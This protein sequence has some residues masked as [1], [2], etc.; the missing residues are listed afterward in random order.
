MNIILN[1]TELH[2][3]VHNYLLTIERYFSTAYVITGIWLL[4]C[5]IPVFTT[6]YV[7]TRLA[8]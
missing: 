4:Y 6:I 2:R 3:T 1:H 7:E 5:N 8:N